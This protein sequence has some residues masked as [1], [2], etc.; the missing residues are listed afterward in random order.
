MSLWVILGSLYLLSAV[1]ALCVTDLLRFFWKE[2]FL[3]MFPMMIKDFSKVYP[4]RKW[5]GPLKIIGYPMTVVFLVTVAT[6]FIAFELLCFL[7]SRRKQSGG[8]RSGSLE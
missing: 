2:I 4:G 3:K 8:P 5:W 1:A 7:R 6:I